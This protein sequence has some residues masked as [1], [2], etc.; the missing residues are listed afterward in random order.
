MKKNEYN[1]FVKQQGYIISYNS[2]TK[3]YIAISHNVYESFLNEELTS[4]E[5]KYPVHYTN[6][7][8]TGFVIPDEKDELSIIRFENKKEAFSS[9]DYNSMALPCNSMALP[10][11]SIALPCNSMA[12]ASNS[13]ARKNFGL[14]TALSQSSYY[15][16]KKRKNIF[17][18]PIYGGEH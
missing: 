13:M 1:I 7:V 4:F 16:S 17:L 15:S 3:N 11:N 14:Q 12:L 8:E 6:F 5:K 9:R 10:C 2:M 18:V